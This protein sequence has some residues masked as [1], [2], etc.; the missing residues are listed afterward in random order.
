[1]WSSAD[2]AVLVP[3]RGRPHRVEPLLASI[4]ATAPAAHVLFL[5]TPEDLEVADALDDEDRL[6]VTWQ[7]A[8]DYARK[9]NH[10][11]EATNE[12]LIFL[13]ADDL[14]FHPGWFEAA[15]SRLSPGI[16][17]VGTN[18]LGN[19]RVLR[20]KHA[21]HCLV[22]RDYAQHGSIDDPSHLLH[23]GY[24]HEYVDDE[25]VGTAKKRNAW[26]FAADSVV[27]H[28]HPHWGKAPTDELYDGQSGRL[29]ASRDLFRRRRRLWM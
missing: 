15:V 11:V 14:E 24:V 25:L 20:G 18:D 8:G 28:L 23:E 26:V 16:G 21:T 12:P 6:E 13:A 5:V 29:A 2:L 1:M 19:P 4:R 10:G 9:I 3:M 22:T 7:P 27:E 17:V